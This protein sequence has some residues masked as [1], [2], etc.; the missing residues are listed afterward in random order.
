MSKFG[1]PGN[2]ATSADP[3]PARRAGPA[4]RGAAQ[5]AGRRTAALAGATAPATR[6]IGRRIRRAG[7]AADR[8]AAGQLGTDPAAGYARK[9][10]DDVKSG[11]WSRACPVD[12]Y[13]EAG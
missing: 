1:P 10:I 8:L 2:P 7:Q 5:R 13:G 3:A 12:G 11:R 9:L 6:T 4:A